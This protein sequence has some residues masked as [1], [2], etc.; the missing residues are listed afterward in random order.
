MSRKLSI[1]LSLLAL[2]LAAAPSAAAAL[3]IESVEGSLGDSA[4]APLLQAGGHPDF[5]IA[6]HMT[7]LVNP[8][9]GNPAPDGNPKDIEVTLPPG[10]IGNPTAVPTCTQGDISVLNFVADC[11]PSTQVGIA[12]ITNYVAGGTETKVPVYNLE[13][14]LG[15][16]AE[17]AFNLYSDI[18]HIDSSV[19][20]DESAP[21]GYRIE[22]KIQNISQGVA[23]GD[24]TLTLW[25]AP[26]SS[27]HDLER[28][29]KGGFP[30]GE[31]VV[32]DV[33]RPRG[34][35]TN[36]TLCDESAQS[37]AAR[38]DSWQ[39]PGAFSSGSYDR[40]PAGNPF[41]FTG[42]DKVPFEASLEAQPTVTRADSPTGLDVTLTLPQNELPEGVSSS[43][44]RDAV[45][46]LP[47]G[48]AIDPSSAA[49]LG[50]CAP[51]QIG[52]G[53][54]A[55][56]SCPAD[57]RIGSVQIDTPLLANPL[58][59]SVYLAQQGQNKYGSLLALYLVVDD[60][61]TGVLL[62]IPGK[63][64][65]DPGSG[66]VVARF[67]DAPQ[68][69][70]RSLRLRLDGGPRASLVTPPACGTYTTQGEFT[71]WSGSGAVVVTDSFRIAQGPAGEACG[72]GRFDPGL[73]AA[74]GD[75]TAGTYSPLEV[76]IS[77]PD[78]SARLGAVS[79][80]L[81]KGL[82][83]K[84]AGVVY[85]PDAALA[86][87]P[88]GEGTGAAQLASPACPG[89]SRVGSVAVA[90]GAGPSPFWVKTGSAYLAGPYKG[91]P[92][93]LA[94]VTPAL[95]G[96][97]DL[98]N[99]VLRVA[100]RV[101]PETAQVSADSDPLPTILAGI[102]LDLREVRVSLDRKG[103]MLNP[104]SCASQKVE[105]TLTAVG[106]TTASPSAWFSAASCE[107]LGFA[108]NLTL[109]LK[110]G[111]RRGAYPQ[112]TAKVNAKP[113]Q[114]NLGRVAVQL[115]HSEFLAQGHIGTVCT[116][117]QF[118]ADQCPPRSVYGY[119]E[120]RTP[121]LDQPLRG[122]VYLRSSSHKLPDLVAALRG[123][124]EIDL[125]GRIDSHNRG[126]RTTFAT[127]PDAPIS[128]FVLRMRGGKKSLLENST[129]LCRRPERAQV[130]MV[131]QNG[132]RHDLSP[133]LG[134]PCKRHR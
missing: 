129:S 7:K 12:S 76:R 6:I 62:K 130:S 86:A 35:M 58:E 125:D 53:N 21:G 29:P 40:D 16:A 117:V 118:A 92:L 99:V 54:G 131:G 46:T 103:F 13:P 80:K 30:A 67:T 127:I 98:G 9:T 34:L 88:T 89:T 95:A 82:L 72:P 93:S 113:G 4:G 77:R 56:P 107:R 74:T 87:V 94:I 22:T 33:G 128:S 102:P 50:S 14:P 25:G 8:A 124:I 47:E 61:T 69:P 5:N 32:S 36:P 38:L 51:G 73:Q 44:L 90:A 71:P 66:R 126:I 17:F 48:M 106:G 43:D 19:V 10:L 111:T 68:L 132:A 75:P 84:L 55:R 3:E 83:G 2:V 42:C 45:V 100:L 114:A 11:S 79:V 64:E 70:V 122:P 49:G 116:R 81:P 115:P 112:L 37:V 123:Q 109:A 119:A 27:S 134:A 101:N 97:F 104:T 24:T 65:T 28:S 91:A 52:L 57:S 133:V 23:I 108:P 39:A 78:G 59:G 31:P 41:V 85:C 63:V 120:A 121:L 96:P 110:G 60:P 18:V 1:V 20:P 105:S 15:V 26:S